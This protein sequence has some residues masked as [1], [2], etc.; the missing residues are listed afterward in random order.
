MMPAT[1]IGQWTDASALTLLEASGKGLILL[2]L[3]AL[4]VA[5]P[6]PARD[7]ELS[8]A[9][10]QKLDQNFDLCIKKKKGPAIREQRP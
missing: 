9:D 3:A 1:W 4:F 5:G 2:A 10:K 6:S 7:P 8:D